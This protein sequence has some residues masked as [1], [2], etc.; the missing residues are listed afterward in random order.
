MSLVRK[1]AST[2]AVEE[3]QDRQT[4]DYLDILGSELRER[5]LN[6]PPVR[7]LVFKLPPRV[8]AEVPPLPLMDPNDL[9][10]YKLSL[11]DAPINISITNYE[12][13]LLRAK[14]AAVRGGGRSNSD[15]S[16]QIEQEFSRLQHEKTSEWLRQQ[17]YA[18]LQ[19]CMDD[20][21]VAIARPR[22]RTTVDTGGV[23][24]I[25]SVTDIELIETARKDYRTKLH[26]I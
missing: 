15:L 8:D 6:L 7:G 24:S 3:C 11:T 25:S 16:R 9:N 17:E 10:F 21:E 12:R 22:S 5:S 4:E 19:D 14:E 26:Q 1:S 23:F 13:W 20:M 18:Q 2:V